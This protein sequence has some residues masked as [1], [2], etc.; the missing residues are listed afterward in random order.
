M[1]FHLEKKHSRKQCAFKKIRVLNFN[2]KRMKNI[3]K[4]CVCVCIMQIRYTKSMSS[5][6]KRMF[7]L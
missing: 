5:S 2:L 1:I 4:V 6:E 7:A 3:L